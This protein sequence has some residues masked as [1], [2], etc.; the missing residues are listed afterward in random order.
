MPFYDPSNTAER[1][2]GTVRVAGEVDLGNNPATVS[3]VLTASLIGLPGIYTIFESIGGF[4]RNGSI[5]APGTNVS[6]YVLLTIPSGYSILSGPAVD[7]TGTK[8]KV[9]IG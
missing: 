7:V 1:A 5:L 9:Q 4:R 2:Y 3:I 6:A 8:I